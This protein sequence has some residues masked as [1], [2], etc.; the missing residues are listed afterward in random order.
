MMDEWFLPK[1]PHIQCARNYIQGSTYPKFN[2]PIA[3][4][5]QSP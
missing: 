4:S 5:C 3:I 1:I 2:L